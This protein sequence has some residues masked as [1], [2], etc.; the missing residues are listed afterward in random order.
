MDWLTT[1]DTLSC[2]IG[3]GWLAASVTGRLT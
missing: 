2:T 3:C 1:E